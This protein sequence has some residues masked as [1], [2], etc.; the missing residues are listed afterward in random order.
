MASGFMGR[1]DRREAVL[2][3][4]AHLLLDGDSG[5]VEILH[6]LVD[7]RPW[8]SPCI[9]H[10]PFHATAV[11]FLGVEVAPLCKGSLHP[12]PRKNSPYKGELRQD[13]N[14][15]RGATSHR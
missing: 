9:L 7:R 10:D 12:A 1:F 13:K 6:G 14:A 3:E 4:V 5:L 15:Q 11:A 2:V 8:P